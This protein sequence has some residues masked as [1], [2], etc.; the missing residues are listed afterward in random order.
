MLHSQMTEL[1]I[2]YIDEND[3]RVA[4]FGTR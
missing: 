4:V 2:S 3:I 1:G